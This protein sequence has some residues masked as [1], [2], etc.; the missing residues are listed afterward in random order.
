[1]FCRVSCRAVVQG[2]S[3]VKSRKGDVASCIVKSGFSVVQ[4]RMVQPGNGG[5]RLRRVLW[6]AVRVPLGMAVDGW[7]RWRCV[8]YG[9]GRALWRRV[10]VSYG[11]VMWRYGGVK[12]GEG[13]V[14]CGSARYCTVA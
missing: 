2:F 1:M 13:K 7:V 8:S 4:S 10:E 3:P 6:S 12:R 11:K 9:E 5:V 14:K